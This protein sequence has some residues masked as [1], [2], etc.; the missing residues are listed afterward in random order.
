MTAMIGISLMAIGVEGFLF[1]KLNWFKR[2][3]LILGGLGCLIPGWRSDVIGLVIG[4]PIIL[5][6]W[7]AIRLIKKSEIAAG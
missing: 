3:F 2:I 6:E 5:W 4:I 7:K 1:R